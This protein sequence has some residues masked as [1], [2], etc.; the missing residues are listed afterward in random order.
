MENTTLIEIRTDFEN[1]AEDF[2]QE[3]HRLEDIGNK[4]AA[5]LIN[6]ER[7]IATEEEANELRVFCETIEEW[8]CPSAPA[9]A[10][11]PIL[12][13]ELDEDFNRIGYDYFNDIGGGEG[14][15]D[16]LYYSPF[17]DSDSK[18]A[19]TFTEAAEDVA[20]AAYDSGYGQA[21]TEYENYREKLA[22]IVANQIN[23]LH[24]EPLRGETYWH[25][26]HR[27]TKIEYICDITTY[28]PAVDIDFESIADTVE[29]DLKEFLLRADISDEKRAAAQTDLAEITACE[30]EYYN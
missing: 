1:N 4:S 27:T 8:D 9:F 16:Q 28:F 13:S 24:D 29:S 20:K 18:S 7:F 2:W 14:C 21:Q 17:S 6:S 5:Q 10:E 23:S 11:H 30:I 25:G 12:F 22:T 26:A 15:V 3:L 19:Y